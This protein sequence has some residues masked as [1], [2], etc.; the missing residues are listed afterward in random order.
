MKSNKYYIL[1]KQFLLRAAVVILNPLAKGPSYAIKGKHVRLY[2][3][4]SQ[5][6]SVTL[7]VVFSIECKVY[8]G[9]EYWNARI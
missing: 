4:Q 2:C 7:Y 6:W 1:N 9:P 8:L 3:I 5:L